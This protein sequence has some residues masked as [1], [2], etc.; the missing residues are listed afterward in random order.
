M[1]SHHRARMILAK[2]VSIIELI[3]KKI[4]N[5]KSDGSLPWS[6]SIVPQSH[7]PRYALKNVAAIVPSI[8]AIGMSIFG[9]TPS[10]LAVS[11]LVR[12]F[13]LA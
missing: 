1:D 7:N 6:L 13:I 4:R 5:T 11:I 12:F 10:V 9:I 3:K 2:M 8:L